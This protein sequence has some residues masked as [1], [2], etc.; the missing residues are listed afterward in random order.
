MSETRKSMLM[1]KR[2]MPDL[3]LQRALCAK[4]VY[5]FL[6]GFFFFVH[7]S[8][9]QAMACV[10]TLFSSI[11]RYFPILFRDRMSNRDNLNGGCAQ[12]VRKVAV[13]MQLQRKVPKGIVSSRCAFREK[14]LR[15]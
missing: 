7:R 3:H 1:L 9:L 6:Y 12:I 14:A 13:S 4:F 11:V 10:F 15:K 8:L 5:D 2:L